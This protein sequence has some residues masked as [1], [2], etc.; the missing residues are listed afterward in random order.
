MTT[1]SKQ[2]INANTKLTKRDFWKVF[3][4]SCTLDSA[5]NYERQQHLMYCY[6]MIP[7]KACRDP[8][9]SHRIPTCTD[10]ERSHLLNF[11][12]KSLLDAGFIFASAVRERREKRVYCFQKWDLCARA[13]PVLHYEALTAGSLWQAD[14]VDKASVKNASCP[15]VW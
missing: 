2:T 15:C 10:R 13:L 9:K 7:G 3:T 8:K 14:R 5:W 1:N 4:R 6:M 12:K 11:K